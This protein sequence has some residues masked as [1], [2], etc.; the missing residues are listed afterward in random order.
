MKSKVHK[1]YNNCPVIICGDFKEDRESPLMKDLVSKDLVDLF[2]LTY[3]DER[4]P[5][6]TTSYYDQNKV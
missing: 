1:Y 4:I 6:Y 5:L 3:R 2:D